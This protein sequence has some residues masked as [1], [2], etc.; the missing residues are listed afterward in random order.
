MDAEADDEDDLDDESDYAERKDDAEGTARYGL[1]ALV[2]RQLTCLAH[3]VNY[4]DHERV[5]PE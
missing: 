4:D 3:Q 5:I 1:A 2:S